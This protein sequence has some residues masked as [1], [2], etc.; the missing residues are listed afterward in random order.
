MAAAS[1]LG[2]ATAITFRCRMET[3]PSSLS[4]A[5]APRPLGG[6]VLRLW[7]TVLL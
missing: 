1:E 2:P 4:R 5:D 3:P 7:N 6:D